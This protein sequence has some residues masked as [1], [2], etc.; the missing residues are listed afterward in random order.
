MT[1]HI[2]VGNDILRPWD[3]PEDV[4]MGRKSAHVIILLFCV[5]HLQVEKTH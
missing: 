3:V 2:K 4:P 1:V 5:W